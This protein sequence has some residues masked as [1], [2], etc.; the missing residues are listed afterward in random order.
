MSDAA[1]SPGLY[2]QALAAA[3]ASGAALA[4]AKPP[5]A[6]A[7][8]VPWRRRN[9]R[10]EVFWV[11]RSEAVPFMP[12]WHAFP[13]GGLARSDAEL[14]VHGEPRHSFAGDTAKSVRSPIPVGSRVEGEEVDPDLVPGVVAAA[15]RELWEE[16]GLLLVTAAAVLDDGAD[17]EDGVAPGAPVAGTAASAL[18]RDAGT[19]ALAAALRERG[20]ALDATQLVWA[21][22]WLTPPFAPLRFDNRF[23]LL[24]WPED[25]A[26]Q[27]SVVPGELA[28][29]EWVAPAAALARWHAGDVLAAPPILHFLR[30]LAED[31]PEAGLRRLHDPVE[32]DLGPFRRIEFRPGVVMVPLRTPTL[33]PATHTNAYLLGTGPM[34]LVD[35]GSPY[36]QEQDRLH[37]AI[38]AATSQLGRRLNAI[39]I[40]HHHPD[41]VGGVAAAA[42]AFD[43][44]VAAHPATAERL[45][46]RGIR[47]NAFFHDGERAE[48]GPGFHVRILHTPGHARG[49]LAFLVEEDSTLLCGDLLSALSTIVIDPP[50]GNMRDY[51]ASLERCR[52]LRP[53]FLFPA[54]GPVLR[55]GERV[56]TQLID[57]RR[58]REARVLAAWKSGVHEADAIV[59]LAYDEAEVPPPLRP[60]AARQVLAHLDHLREQGL[61]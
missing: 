61:L 1:P 8:V 52:E 27:P 49:H 4:L 16:T 29:G 51:L 39:W 15:L 41:H 47:V 34:V 57:H 12:G 11:R 54:H 42:A 13:G 36:P 5:R 58:D 23:F 35:P 21:G 37:A 28:E 46:A 32:A 45:A 33:P 40:T 24:E 10:I 18:P 48:L 26:Q 44:P 53:R 3:A 60:I 20:L 43:V 22:R 6:S 50:E 30:V 19:A 14:P 59:P 38:A 31:A 55:D 9:G 17:P 25:R 2:E 56:L 7:G